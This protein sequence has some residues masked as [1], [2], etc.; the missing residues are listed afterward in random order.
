VSTITIDCSSELGVALGKRQDDVANEIKLMAALKLYETG[1][2][3]SGLAARLAGLARVDFLFL[4]KSHGITI[5]QQNEDE[6][7][8]DK[9]NALNP[10]RS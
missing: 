1:R 8:S 6:V 5:F 4:C 10:C 9:I 3:S 7:K 2:I